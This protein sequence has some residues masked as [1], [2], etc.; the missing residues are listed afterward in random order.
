MNEGIAVPEALKREGA[1][2]PGSPSRPSGEREPT[3]GPEGAGSDGGT[4][5]DS[6]ATE[7]PGERS[8]TDSTG[9]VATGRWRI[10]FAVALVTIGIGI[11]AES[12]PI[13]AAS[14]VGLT[15]AAAGRLIP[16]PTLDLTVERSIEPASPKP[17]STPTVT[18]SVTND[19]RH[20][21]PAVRI[22]DT[23]PAGVESLDN[24]RTAVSI[25]PGETATL[26]YEVR[27]KR[28]AHD[29]GDVR[30]LASNAGDGERR[31][32]TAAVETTLRCEDR[33]DDVSV[34]GQ[35]S[36]HAGRIGSTDGGSGVEF[37]AIRAYQPT[38]PINR[39]D[40]NRLARTGELAT[41]DFRQE[42]AVRVV[43]VV[44][45][46]EEFARVR[47]PGEA[48][49]L[50][51]SRHA[52]DHLARA[53]LA[54]NNH[55]GVACFGGR[56]HYLRPG[57][58]RT[59]VARIERVLEGD[60]KPSFGRSGWLAGG[61]ADVD[62]CCRELADEKHLVLVSPLLDHEPVQAASRFAAY[63][64]DVTVV[65]PAVT[66]ETP[67]GRLA[68]IDRESRLSTLRGDGVHV[69]D[70]SPAEPLSVAMDRAARRWS[71]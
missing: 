49:A 5:A 68:A 52:A 55:V 67:G 70:W 24:P 8:R 13:F 46:R 22:V 38:D 57:A 15:Y 33:V 35:T 23:P 34:V 41:I 17:S 59:Q 10:G 32:E 39:V 9:A 43:C 19:G 4:A 45:D 47:R 36:Q 40:W 50:E 12:L 37:H 3:V 20:A 30:I 28:G 2:K 48:D 21:L 44:D 56:G 42:R 65:S 6:D 16:P 51:L 54:A 64:Y 1:G 69:V 71:A 66:P 18:V 29:F 63:G 25:Q 58:G 62:R 31:T 53:L 60:W 27:A 11:L 26:R 61:V 7:G 14:L